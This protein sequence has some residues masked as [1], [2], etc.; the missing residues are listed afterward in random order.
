[1]SGANSGKKARRPK[2]RSRKER[3]GDAVRKVIPSTSID[4][5]E[6]HIFPLDGEGCKANTCETT[7]KQIVSYLFEKGHPYIAQS[8]MH[9]SLIEPDKPNPPKIVKLDPDDK[10][11]DQAAID[12]ENEVNKDIYLAELKI[13][14]QQKTKFKEGKFFAVE[15]LLNQC[16]DLMKNQLTT[17]DK[18]K[19]YVKEGNFIEIVKL[20]KTCSASTSGRGY[21]IQNYSVSQSRIHGCRQR[22][23]ES[24]IDYKDRLRRALDRYYHAGGNFSESLDFSKDPTLASLTTQERKDR[25]EAFFLIFNA[26]N[27]RYG[28]LKSQLHNESTD[29]QDTWPTTWAKAWARLDEY[30]SPFESREKE[31]EKPKN[32]DT[33]TGSSFVMKGEDG[34]P[35]VPGLNGE[36]FPKVQCHKCKRYG[37]YAPQC[38]ICPKKSGGEGKEDEDDDDASETNNAQHW[39]EGSEQNDDEFDSEPG[40][41]GT[42]N[43]MLDTDGA[44]LAAIEIKK[45]NKS[46]IILL[47]SGSTHHVFCDASLLTNIRE[48]S[49]PLTMTTNAGSFACNASGIFPGLG[50]VWLNPDGIVNVMS[51][52]KLSKD[53]R[54]KVQFLTKGATSYY[55]V[56]NKKNGR[57]LRFDESKGV[58]ECAVCTTAQSN[59]KRDNSNMSVKNYS[60]ALLETVASKS[61]LL[62]PRERQGVKKAEHLIQS[63]GYPSK[64]DVISIIAANIILDCPISVK[65]IQN[66]YD[67]KGGLESVL[68]GKTAR[69]QTG[70]VNHELQ[71]TPV[72]RGM[73]PPDR[74]IILCVDLF[75]V[76]RNPFLISLSKRILFTTAEALPNRD[77]D[78]IYGAICRVIGF[79]RSYGH[80]IKE[81]FAD[82]E[83]GAVK[84]DIEQYNGVRTDLATPNEHVPDIERNIRVVKDR[85]RCSIH[86]MPYPSL[87]R[88]FKKDLVL[89]LVIMLNTIPRKAGI[90]EYY[91]PWTLITGRKLNYKLHCRVR[92][93]E[94]CMTH[95]EEKPRNS[96]KARATN[97]VAIGPCANLHG[98][99][100]FLHLATG[101]IIKRKIFTPLTITQD[102]INRMTELS[103]RSAAH[104]EFKYKENTFSTADEDDGIDGIGYLDDED[105]VD[106][107]YPVR[108][109]KNQN[110][111][112]ENE[113][114]DAVDN[115]AVFSDDEGNSDSDDEIPPAHEQIGPDDEEQLE[116]DLPNEDDK[117]IEPSEVRNDRRP[118][119][120]NTRSAGRTD[121][122][123]L[124]DKQQ[125]TSGSSFTQFHKLLPDPQ[126]KDDFFIGQAYIQFLNKG[127][128]N[129]CLTRLL[130]DDLESF[131]SDT[132][133][134]MFN[135]MSLKKGLETFGVKAE[136]GVMKEFQQFIDRKVL[137]PSMATALS[138]IEKDEA[139]RLIM[140]IKEK[141]CGKIKGRACA[142]GR[143]LRSKIRAE[144]A[145]SPTVSTEAFLM[146]C[147]I[148]AKE[149]R[150]VVTC[151]VPG[152]YL[153]CEM[154]EVCHVLLEGV[155]VDLYVK[156]DPSA[157]KYITTNRYGK[158]LLY[159]RMNKALYRHMRSGRLFWEHISKKLTSMGFVSNPEDPCVMNKDIAG[160][161]C[162]VVLHVDDLKI[163]HVDEDALKW[164]LSEL[165]EEYGQLEIQEGKVLE[166]LGLELDYSSKGV[167]K[168]GAVEYIKKAVGSY[169]GER[170]KKARTPAGEDLF[171]INDASPK[172]E[173]AARK[174]FHSTFA[175][176]LWIG[177]MAR[178]DIL[179]ALSFLGKRTSKASEEDEKKLLRLLGYLN[180]TMEKKL[181]LSADEMHV[182]KWWAD[183]SFGVHDDLKSHS[184]LLGTLG[185]GAIFAKSS[186]QRLNTISSTEAEIVASSE[187]LTQII[188]TTSFLRHQGFDVKNAVLHQD[189]QAA[190]LM[191][192]NGVLSRRR[193]SRHI[194]I[195]FFFVK[196]RVD[197]GEIEIVY[198]NTDDMRADFLT[199]PL[200]GAKFRDHRA[201]ILGTKTDKAKECVGT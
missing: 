5:L 187:V 174:Q 1:M 102:V 76:D 128:S 81:L 176:C 194:N 130:N 117:I 111:P 147:A 164:V 178:P 35:V 42:N 90:S 82:N 98:T 85:T 89:S 116:E 152:A 180:D 150:L 96:T 114:V 101:D 13:Y 138:K 134:K 146:T 14:V 16:T 21:I 166:Y 139:L 190:I 87:P 175:L 56:E 7:L 26:C 159:T 133:A 46:F 193:R 154:D 198:C 79:Y 57:K 99:Y 40:N 104:I 19:S 44:C 45:I 67:L 3:Q 4:A 58:Y 25:F 201:I 110:E 120:S 185:R 148:D 18:Y 170:I 64:R 199:K 149:N 74:G 137:I 34:K 182:T 11:S 141:R 55:T 140:T 132:D 27:K 160:K 73:L 122:I 196:D 8:V 53:D 106:Y 60:L 71:S 162:T 47:D 66:L 29:D 36:V 54:F 12:G 32:E 200:Q 77:G 30:V 156:V 105:W 172:L 151:D 70:H 189:N 88:N 131:C 173:E 97:A 181:T 61:A 84:K 192:E 9:E 167:V 43:I 108:E 37:H 24:N 144:D 62:T 52:S 127:R 168:I 65:D 121:H 78:T 109:N 39:G 183:S 10:E 142:D 129:S 115:A 59:N 118:V 157:A 112:Q 163:S 171:K 91:S 95:E 33:H 145:R 113:G 125:V 191:Q 63:L 184:G 80:N 126:F 49:K 31:K 188:W 103:K 92:P 51:I 86:D 72:P 23:D 177:V 135:Q 119:A 195:R 94:Y 50:R 136:E 93:G 20:I 153:H 123:H 179:V 155:L 6:A 100:K 158:K 197:K 186:G 28:S 41:D 38:P 107:D 169:D 22:H 15:V 143:P 161:Q 48:E 69:T 17:Y 165:E 2:Y 124:N 75:F 68:K 83:F